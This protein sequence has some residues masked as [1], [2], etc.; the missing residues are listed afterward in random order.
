MCIICI[1][2]YLYVC[3]IN[4]M[5]HEEYSNIAFYSKNKLKDNKKQSYCS[6][7]DFH[8]NDH[9]NNFHLCV[10]LEGTNKCKIMPFRN[11]NLTEMSCQS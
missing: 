11:L 10:L 2:N 5:I 9:Y 4:I 7:V 8:D 1:T 6:I 3:H